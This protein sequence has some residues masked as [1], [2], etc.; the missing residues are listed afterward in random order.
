MKVTILGSTGNLGQQCLR[1]C[2]DAGHE[3]TVLVRHPNKVPQNLRDQITVVEGDALNLD[4]VG[5]AMSHSTDAILFAIGIDERSSPEDLCTDVTRHILE[6][7]RNSSIS[8]LVWCGG[9]SNLVKE[10]VVTFGARFVR[11]YAER[12]LN[13]PTY[14]QRASARA[15]G[16][17]QGPEL[18]RH[19]PSPD[20]AWKQGGKLPPGVQRFRAHVEN[21]LCRLRPCHGEHAQ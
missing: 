9:G 11:W 18:D 1:Q 15:V 6:T 4:D 3:V 2:L 21:Q 19:S 16:E 14:R 13:T 5:R 12:F 8:R 20:E 17:K 10:D 7:M